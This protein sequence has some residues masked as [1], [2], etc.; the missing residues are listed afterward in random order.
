M[1]L[2][3]EFLHGRALIHLLFLCLRHEVTGLLAAEWHCFEL[4]LARF[5]ARRSQ[6]TF[7]TYLVRL[8]LELIELVML[9]VNDVVVLRDK[10]RRICKSLNLIRRW[11]SFATNIN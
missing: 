5:S 9:L 3:L 4:I 7:V 1:P 11:P 10:V 8:K 2:P 6:E